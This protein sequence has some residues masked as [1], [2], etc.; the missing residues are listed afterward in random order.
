V[1]S[2]PSRPTIQ[3]PNAGSPAA[4]VLASRG[5]Q[6]A[7]PGLE[8]D[9]VIVGA[10]SAGATLAA[11]LSQDPNIQVALIEAGPDYRSA[12]APE[13]MR[14][15]NPSRIITEPAFEHLRYPAL[16][17]RRTRAQAPR[18]YWRGRGVGGSS[19]INGQIA[20]RGTVEDY[21]GWAAAGCA[22]WSF[23]DVLP[24]FNRLETDLRFGDAP[25]HGDRG[26]IPIYR[27]PIAKWGAVDQA[28]AEAAL[29]LGYA[30]AADHNAPHA[31]GVSPYAINSRDG[32]RV[33][34]ND[35]YLEPARGRNNLAIFGDALVDC[36][37]FEGTRAVGVRLRRPGGWREL[38]GRTVILAAG[39]VHSPAILMRSGIGP[40]GHLK[41]LDIAVRAE[42]PVGDGFQDHPLC[43]FAVVLEDFAT[44][45]PGFRHTNCC[46]RY[47]SQ[48]LGAPPGDMMLVFMN[49]L[50]D[51][52]ARR[53][54][55]ESG[56]PFGIMGTW[57]NACE[58]RG[59]VRLVSRD[60]ATDPAIEENMLDTES[61][62]LRL[63]DG[64]RRL[65]AVARQDGFRA[66]GQVTAEGLDLA[67]EPSDSEL[68]AWAQ[69]NAGDTQHGT[70]S[71]RMGAADDTRS[72]VDPACR[73]LGF[74]G[75]RVI[76]ASI[77]PS[78]VCA[79]TH[80]T[81]VMIAEKMAAELA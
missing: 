6:R 19:A 28:G 58:S 26:P 31:L 11:R 23:D 44:P 54:V 45:P 40:A 27:A 36:V 20:I 76:D 5:S 74:D 15:P 50:G 32:V 73:V 55:A 41:S 7:G 4:D 38:R 47:S 2:I 62:R 67:R 22:G 52:L 42:L 9:F 49:R 14:L 13:A 61:D 60:P 39:A 72:V 30:W 51:S 70:S 37:V 78:V 17:A 1:G 48:M 33:S 65:I 63:R 21:D 64:L 34:T 18:L 77:M 66:I 29:D 3:S 56:K 8:Y 25:W 69:A 57:L 12:D 71:C 68:D 59:T 81:T 46:V 80:L 53:G 35:A 10:G 79:N 43:A 75:L 16:K 24:F